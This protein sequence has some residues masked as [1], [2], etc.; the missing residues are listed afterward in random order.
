MQDLS[1]Q[2][3]DSSVFLN[4][5]WIFKAHTQLWTELFIFRSGLTVT[6]LARVY[7]VSLHCREKFTSCTFLSHYVHF[8]REGVDGEWALGFRWTTELTLPYPCC[9]FT[10]DLFNDVLSRS[11]YH[12]MITELW[13]RKETHSLISTST[14]AI[15]WT[16]LEKTVRS[17][18]NTVFWDVAS[19]RSCVNRRFGGTYPLHLQDST[20]D[21]CSRWFLAR[22][23][24]YPE[25]GGYNFLRNV[26]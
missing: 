23:F 18:K 20:T 3:S 6:G 8:S 9:P 26:G 4:A 7:C 25:D 12:R 22:G 13:I 16:K 10:C 19:C 2:T 14:P 1:E 11:N 24:F 17:R 21:T 15:T 5:M